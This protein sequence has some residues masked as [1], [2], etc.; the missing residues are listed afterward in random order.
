MV[1]TTPAQ[2]HK[3]GTA[4]LGPGDV[5]PLL[6]ALTDVTAAFKTTAWAPGPGYV[7]TWSSLR[8][9]VTADARHKLTGSGLALFPASCPLRG[10]SPLYM[11]PGKAH[12]HSHITLRGVDMIKQGLN[13]HPF[14]WNPALKRERKEGH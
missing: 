8:L 2:A 5:Q 6:T 10:Q 14:D 12:P 7:K 11:Y 4:G 13:C 3:E 1:G 9:G